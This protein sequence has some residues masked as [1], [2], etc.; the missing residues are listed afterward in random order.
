MILSYILLMIPPI[1]HIEDRTI[2]QAA[3]FT[4]ILSFVSLIYS[5]S[6]LYYITLKGTN[7]LTID[8]LLL[9]SQLSKLWSDD[10]MKAAETW[11]EDRQEGR[12]GEGRSLGVFFLYYWILNLKAA[13]LCEM[14]NFWFLHVNIL[15]IKFELSMFE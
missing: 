15:F 12:R 11:T 10:I 13:E 2:D 9:H 14:F 8:F 1:Y 5:G 6:I 3:H 4:T 7:K